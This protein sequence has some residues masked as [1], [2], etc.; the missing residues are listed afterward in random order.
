MIQLEDTIIS[1]DLI[2]KF[3]ICDLKQCKGECC[4][5]G[6]A[7]AP[8][9][10]EEFEILRKILP[11]IWEDLSPEAQAVINKQG[12]GYIDAENDIVTSIVNGKN[13]VF[14]YHDANGI[15]KCAIEKAYNEGRI[16][17]MKPISC[18]LY[19][20]R[21][22]RYRNYQAV[23]YH[24]WKICRAAEILGEQKGLPVYQFL[25]EPLIRKFG[26]EWYN[27]LDT[28]AKEYKK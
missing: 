23:N 9:E 21:V 19:P 11:A 13:C 16:K 5:E 8:L 15:C 25:R 28:C 10:K 22:V 20:V 2:E 17:F 26:E 24:R 4:I 3:F 6:D 7:G 12:V 18:H 1:L 27:A 14:T